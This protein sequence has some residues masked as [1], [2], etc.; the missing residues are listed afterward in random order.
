MNRLFLFFIFLSLLFP[1][2]LSRAEILLNRAD[3]LI[4][5]NPNNPNGYL[6]Y[7]SALNIVMSEKE[8]DWDNYSKMYDKKIN[9]GFYNIFEGVTVQRIQQ[10]PDYFSSHIRFAK[11]FEYSK[12]VPEEESFDYLLDKILTFDRINNILMT[13]NKDQ[14]YIDYHQNFGIDKINDIFE[15]LMVGYKDVIIY[16]LEHDG[17]EYVDR[18]DI[19]ILKMNEEDDD[20][21]RVDIHE[22]FADIC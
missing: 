8:D 18:V 17:V 15:Y 20:F 1:Q 16:Q 12:E 9:E 6:N 10:N 4:E 13:D 11:L 14:L 2:E 21:Y 3:K 22:Y 19:Y 7:L 5:Q